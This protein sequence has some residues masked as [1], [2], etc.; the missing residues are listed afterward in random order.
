M[1]HKALLTEEDYLEALR[2]VS[3]LID[4]DPDIDTPDGQLLDILGKLVQA[5]E[6]EHYPD[7]K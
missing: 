3:E 7:W 4:I 5:Y 1:Q 6:A 2:K